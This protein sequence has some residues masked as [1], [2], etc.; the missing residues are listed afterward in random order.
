MKVK[1]NKRTSTPGE[2]SKEYTVR[3]QDRSK[4]IDRMEMTI[5]GDRTIIMVAA[6]KTEAVAEEVVAAMEVIITTR[7]DEITVLERAG[8]VI[9]EEEEVEGHEEAT[10]LL[11]MWA[12]VVDDTICRGVSPITMITW[13]QVTIML[14]FRRP[15]VLELGAC[16]M[17]NEYVNWTSTASVRLL[18]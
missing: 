13:P 10:S 11:T 1:A 18:G 17:A 12:R 9:I 8:M 14:L 6:I 16:R 5:I 7:V 4:I 15:G 2:I 3:H